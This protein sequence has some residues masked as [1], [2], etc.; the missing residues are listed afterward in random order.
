MVFLFSFL[1]WA[2]DVVFFYLIYNSPKNTNSN[3]GNSVSYLSSFEYRPEKKVTIL[4]ALLDSV[5]S[6]NQNVSRCV[7]A[8]GGGADPEQ[9]RDTGVGVSLGLRSGTV[10]A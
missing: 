6:L 9:A 8:Y 3:K 2:V 7:L 10:L 4:L 1:W 5:L